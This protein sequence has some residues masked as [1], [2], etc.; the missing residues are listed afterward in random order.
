MEIEHIF[1]L[2][3]TSEPQVNKKI[4]INAKD[5]NNTNSPLKNNKVIIKKT[6]QTIKI[7]SKYFFPGFN[8]SFVRCAISKPIGKPAKEII[9]LKIIV[10]IF[11]LD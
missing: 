7:I 6:A 1:Y 8:S 2:A 4:N 9:T 3:L 10:N 5:K 11:I